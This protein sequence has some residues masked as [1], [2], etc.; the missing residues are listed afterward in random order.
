[1]RQALSDFEVMGAPLLAVFER[2]EAFGF[3]SSCPSSTVEGVP[4]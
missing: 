2:W 4:R 1:M 3:S